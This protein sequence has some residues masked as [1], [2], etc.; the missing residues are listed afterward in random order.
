MNKILLFI[1]M[2]AVFA[3]CKNDSP[4]PLGKI[5]PIVGEWRVISY[6]ATDGTTTVP[7][8]SMKGRS[9]ITV[10]RPDGVIVDGFGRMPCCPAS[11]YFFNDKEFIPRPSAPIEP[12]LCPMIFCGACPEMRI[13]MPAP[14]T[15]LV[16]NCG[17]GTSTLVREK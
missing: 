2:L 13:T 17:G 5:Q 11:K 9:L 7:D 12:S 8:T 3:E 6:K 15:L 16:Q 10:I 14:D 1:M 4:L